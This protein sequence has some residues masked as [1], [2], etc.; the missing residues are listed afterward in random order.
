MYY[1]QRIRDL[2]EDSD[3][4]QKEISD[5]LGIVTSQ[6][7]RYESGK[8]EIPFHM[9]IKLSNL[10]DVSLDYI[11]G[12]TNDKQ[13]LS[14]SNLNELE[15]NLINGFRKLDGIGKGRVIEK[16]ESLNMK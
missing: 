14:K 1:Y 10:Y 7:Q 13:G 6:Y 12:R 5:Y 15:I 16:I 9:V 2:R 8:R 3:K 11:S 4:T